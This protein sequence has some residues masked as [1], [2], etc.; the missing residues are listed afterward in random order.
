M[1]NSFSHEVMVKGQSLPQAPAAA[2]GLTLGKL[3][4]RLQQV[5]R[6]RNHHEAS[7]SYLCFSWRTMMSFCLMYY[8]FIFLDLGFLDS[9]NNKCRSLIDPFY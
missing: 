8:L 5:A 4:L 7:S 3:V 6:E 9:Y 1:D 2:S